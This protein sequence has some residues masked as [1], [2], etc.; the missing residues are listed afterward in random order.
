MPHTCSAGT[1]KKSAF[2]L[3][4]AAPAAIALRSVDLARTQATRADSH[5]L[6]G[7]VNDC[8]HLANVG[9]PRSVGLAMRVRNRL[10][11]DDTLSADATLCHIDTSS[12]R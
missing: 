12:M 6:G 8:L 3:C 11:E 10:S 5:S 2:I 9:L 4:D 1:D 7:T